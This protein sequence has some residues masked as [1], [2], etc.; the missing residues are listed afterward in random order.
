MNVTQLMCRNVATCNATESLDAAARKMWESDV[1]VLPVVDADNRVVGILTD[2]DVCMAA[3]T[4]G[5][6]LKELTVDS[7]MER[8]VHT[9]R[10]TDR[11][12]DVEAVMRTFKV[13]RVPIVDADGRLVGIV[14]LNDL[15]REA[16]AEHRRKHPDIPCDELVT[17]LACIGEPRRQVDSVPAAAE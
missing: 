10:S 16:A 17:T 11:I 1:G 7:A 12:Q 8:T 9:R 3:Y 13:R 14:S 15:T 5:R 6:S 4:Q 2:R